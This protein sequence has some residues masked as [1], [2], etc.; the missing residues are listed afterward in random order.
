MFYAE[1]LLGLFFIFFWAAQIFFV[2]KHMDW[3]YNVIDSN[4]E[5]EKEGVT[6]I[7]PIKDLDFEFEKNVMST[8]EQ[9]YRGPLQHVF[10]FQDENDP[11]IPVVKR[12]VEDYYPNLDAA[13]T[14]NPLIEGLNG[15]SSNMIHGMKLAKYQTLVFVD[16]DIRVQP[17]FIVKMVRPLRKHGV[18]MT[19]CGQVNIGGKDFWTRFFTFLQNSETDFLWAFFTKLNLN[20]GA[21]GAAFAMRKDLLEKVGGL[22]RFGSSLLED[23]HLGE[24]LYKMGYK[25]VLGPFVECHVN[26]L[27][28]ERSL[29]YAKRIGVGI[30][31]HIL[32]E[33]PL[34]VLMLSWYWIFLM[35]GI[36]TKSKGVIF[37]SLIFL[38]FRVI[39]SLLMRKVTKNEIKIVDFIMGPLFDIFGSFYL[40][41]ALSNPYV[42][43]RGIRYRV[44]K[45]GYIQKIEV[46]EKKNS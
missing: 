46:P 2:K 4:E 44:S 24:T 12:L 26:V 16:S 1:L 34:F 23:F 33:L 20:M 21:T 32:T 42:E 40:L 39:Q 41:Y 15:K 29:N 3:T 5:D 28:M 30:K 8:F 14:V 13:I 31:T 37:L 45:G 11:A 19:T 18:G 38:F 25:L 6:I 9:N 10:S 35:I 22:E 7:H 43:W 36:L 27:P 17:D